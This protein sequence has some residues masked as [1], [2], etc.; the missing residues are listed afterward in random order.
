MFRLVA[1]NRE[2]A[3]TAGATGG[4]KKSIFTFTKSGALPIQDEIWQLNTFLKEK[5]CPISKQ[6]AEIGLQTTSRIIEKE[7]ADLKI[8]EFENNPSS[9]SPN[10]STTPVNLISPVPLD[11]EIIDADFDPENIIIQITKPTDQTLKQIT[12]LP[13]DIATDHQEIK[14]LSTPFNRETTRN[15]EAKIAQKKLC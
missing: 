9:S 10:A 14:L 1:S 4:P 6:N 5:C 12:D 7:N 15:F 8:T 2:F 13:S 11:I 3:V